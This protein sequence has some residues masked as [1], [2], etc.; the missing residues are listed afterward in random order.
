[1]CISCPC[2]RIYEFIVYICYHIQ[3]NVIDNLY[4]DDI[5]FLHVYI[6]IHTHTHTHT[7]IYIYIYIFIYIISR[8]CESI[9][10]KVMIPVFKGWLDYIN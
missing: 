2:I 7:H 6:Y 9:T 4:T 3:L 1:M 10:Q 5:T 8:Y